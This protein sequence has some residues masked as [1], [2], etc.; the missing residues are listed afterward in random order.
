MLGIWKPIS[1]G[2]VCD[3]PLAVVDASTF[4]RENQIENHLH[5]NFIFKEAHNLNGGVSYNPD[6]KWYYYPHQTS[7]D[8]LI[9]HQ[10]SKVKCL[11][12]KI[13]MNFVIP[14]LE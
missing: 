9:F 5:M 1:A 11:T 10:Y 3:F 14:I 12:V 6:Q 7:R 4:S 8:V 2:P 13:I